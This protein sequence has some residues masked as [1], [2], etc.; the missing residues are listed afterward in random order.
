M[1]LPP[2]V[3]DFLSGKRIAVAGVSRDP[4]QTAN[5]IF[6][7]LRASGYEVIPVNPN[8]TEAEGVRCYPDLGSIPGS[9][10]GLV[11]VTPAG[12]ALDLVRQCS[13]RRV[14]R[15]WFHSGIGPGSASAEAVRECQAR[16]LTCIATGCPFMYVAP[17]DPFHRCMRWVLRWGGHVPG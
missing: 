3:A 16:G 4:K 17:I 13:E 15:I 6:R 10:D 5:A 1:A 7:K 11:A 14:P 2:I 9:L 8:A 12:A